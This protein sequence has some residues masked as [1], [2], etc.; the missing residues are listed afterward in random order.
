MNDVIMRNNNV[1]TVR[2]AAY[3]N[4]M[5]IAVLASAAVQVQHPAAYIQAIYP[6]KLPGAA[7]ELQ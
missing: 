4:A 6:A 5:H 2:T 1:I 7:A 3:S